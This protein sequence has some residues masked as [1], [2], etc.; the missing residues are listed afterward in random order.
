[1]V[2]N[3]TAKKAPA[4]KS[5]R[6][7]KAIA[8]KTPAKKAAKKVAKKAAKK[9]T[10]AKKARAQKE[11]LLC[12][13][14]QGTSTNDTSSKLKYTSSTGIWY[15]FNL[16]LL[17]KGSFIVNGTDGIASRA[18][19]Q[20]KVIKEAQESPFWQNFP[21]RA[22][23]DAGLDY[24]V[25]K[26]AQTS[27]LPEDD[28]RQLLQGEGE[29]LGVD[30]RSLCWFNSEDE[31]QDVDDLAACVQSIHDMTPDFAFFNPEIVNANNPN[32]DFMV[33][34]DHP[35]HG[36]VNVVIDGHG[37]AELASAL[38]KFVEGNLKEGLEIDCIVHLASSF[39]SQLK[40]ADQ[41]A[42]FQL[43]Y[44]TCTGGSRLLHV[45]NCGNTKLYL[46]TQTG[47]MIEL[48]MDCE[49]IRH[50]GLVKELEAKK[51]LVTTDEEDGKTRRW[52]GL[53]DFQSLG[54]V[55]PNPEEAAAYGLTPNTQELHRKTVAGYL[56][57]ALEEHTKRVRQQF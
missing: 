48:T 13:R 7:N 52:G 23:L 28:V 41:G 54:D 17:P 39:A 43:A 45:F 29:G 8:K 38:M 26:I 24:L 56:P 10:S 50:P 35:N 30:A 2:K 9:P 51:L 37:G 25:P 15:T 12:T 33:R 31:R 11:P 34:V 22:F 16:D 4:K 27:R 42:A 1:M 55:A 3:A 20:P 5:T 40:F 44:V 6:A 32:E 36:L 46:L 18:W 21:A 49:Y 57:K 14:V 53:C 47:E 19:S